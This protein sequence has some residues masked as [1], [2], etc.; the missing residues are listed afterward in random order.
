MVN[1]NNSLNDDRK[2]LSLDFS[3]S[4]LRFYLGLQY[5]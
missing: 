1:Y 3:M 5:Y 4:N 2:G